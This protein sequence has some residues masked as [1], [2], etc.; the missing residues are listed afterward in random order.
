MSPLQALG[1]F[2]RVALVGLIGGVLA[3][4]GSFVI[5]PTY[6]S[7]TK[8]LVRGRDTTFLTSSGETLDQQGALM[9]SQIA[10]VLSETQTALLSSHEVAATVVDELGLD[11]PREEPQGVIGRVRSL[12]GDAYRNGKALLIHGFV[13]DVDDRTKAIAGVHQGLSASQVED[14]YVIDVIGQADDPLLASAIA[15]AAADALI[16]I[17]EDRLE[18]ESATYRDFLATQVDLAEE[19]AAAAAEEVR[20]YKAEHDI[21]DVATEL[22]LTAESSQSLQ[23]QLRRSEIELEARRASLAAIDRSLSG[24]SRDARSV[25]SIETGR[26][27]TEIVNQGP[28]TVHQTLTS[29]RERASAEIAALEAERGAIEE[30]LENGTVTDRD[31]TDEEATLRRLESRYAA[32]NAAYQ[33]LRT[34]HQEAK[35]SSGDGRTEL[36]RMDAA[37]VPVYPVKPGRYL[38]LA[39]GLVVG[40][41]LGLLRTVMVGRREGW[42]QDLG[43]RLASVTGT[44]IDHAG[45][46]AAP[47]HGLEHMAL[48]EGNGGTPASTNRSDEPAVLQV[49]PFEVFRSKESRP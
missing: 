5:D 17:S 36:T 18:T 38:F 32:A 1:R 49:G 6:E 29:D 19:E 43:S 14:S 26:S 2:W 24:I 47:H 11:R 21:S 25:Q 42:W 4:A 44:D 35:L 9:D 27:S 31:L 12:A 39:L 46:R 30:V 20:A 13:A 45:S 16:E 15:D 7:T 22:I 3:F 40:A 34:R 48:H 41:L 37:S 33:D 8:L 10:S 23:E 28:N